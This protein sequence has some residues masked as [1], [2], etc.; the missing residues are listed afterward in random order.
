M[1]PIVFLPFSL[2]FVSVF[3]SSERFLGGGSIFLL[4]LT[5]K[6]KKFIDEKINFRLEE[7]IDL[8]GE[9]ERKNSD[10]S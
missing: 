6:H 7:F 3:G 1:S 4:L 8:L 2:S 10:I 5:F 9:N